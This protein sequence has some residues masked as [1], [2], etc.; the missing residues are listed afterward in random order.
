MTPCPSAYV[1]VPF[2]RHRCGYCNFTLVAG[3]DDLIGG[4][5]EA[6][7]LELATL[8]EPRE[9]ETLFFGGGTPTHLP[10]DD[11]RRLLSLVS[12]WLPLAAG[13]E[14]SVEANPVDLCGEKVDVLSK[15]GV[16]RVSLGAQSFD[17]DKLKLLER[18]HRAATIESAVRIARGFAGSVSLDLI[19]GAPGETLAGWQDDLSR[20]LALRPDHVS[21]YGLTIEKGTAFWSR[22][23]KGALRGV[24]ENLERQMYEGAIDALTAAG[25]EHYEVSNFAQPGHRCRHNENY[26]LGDS[27]F[28]FGPGAARFIDGRRE[29]NHRS[30]S[31]YIQRVLA[32]QSPVAEAERLEPED[33]A[34]ERLVFALRRLEGIDID[35]FAD[36]SGFS[37]D[38]LVGS[39]LPAL[40]EQGLFERTASRLKLTREGLLVSD[41]IWPK[42]LRS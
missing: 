27:Y 42:F 11:I 35:R 20:A 39:V 25:H 5:L 28:A 18:D 34:R 14:F 8:G 16:T 3:R 37:L 22:A 41:A 31:T 4:Y 17:K 24:E 32:G 38:A 1:H 6:L 36:Q 40:I 30:T 29:T 19:F 33:A 10:P 13:G 26:W 12:Q 7:G 9:V 2:C 15:A 21:T 23:E